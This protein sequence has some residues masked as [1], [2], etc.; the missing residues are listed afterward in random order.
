MSAHFTRKDLIAVLSVVVIWGLNFVAAKLALQQVSPFQ[1][2][3]LRYVFATLPF[4]FFIRPPKIAAKW[5]IAYGL[6][7]G[8]G[9]FGFLYFS[10]TLGM[11]ASL[12]S[13]IMQTQVFFTAVFGFFMLSERLSRL[14]LL[15]L[16]FAAC[17]LI[18][19]GISTSGYNMQPKYG[20]TF[21][22]LVLCTAS[23]ASWALSNVLTRKISQNYP[24]YKPLGLIVW[25]SLVPILPFA[26]LSQIFDMQPISLEQIKTINLTSWLGAAYLGWFATILAYALWATLLKKYSANTVAPFSLSVPLIGL[27]AGAIAFAEVLSGLQWIGVFFIGIALALA[28]SLHQMMA[29][30]IRKLTS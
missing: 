18:A 20:V 23:A 12:A 2:G 15:G 24:G 19:F 25:S 21:V 27:A 5:I 28:L 17:G 26:V 10:L 3:V 14:Q 11:T 4:V 7:Q 29:Q 1:L 30:Q 13:V 8:V 6:V 9:Q 16:F 22:G